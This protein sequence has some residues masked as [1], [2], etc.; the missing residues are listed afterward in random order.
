M[1][2]SFPACAAAPTTHAQ[3]TSTSRSVCLGFPLKNVEST[4]PGGVEQGLSFSETTPALQRSK[5]ANCGAS[6]PRSPTLINEL[7][8][9]VSSQ[10]VGLQTHARGVECQEFVQ[11]EVDSD[12]NQAWISEPVVDSL[13]VSVGAQPATVTSDEFLRGGHVVEHNESGTWVA[14]PL[15]N[16]PS[17]GVVDTR[18]PRTICNGRWSDWGTIDQDKPSVID[19]DGERNASI[20]AAG[21]DVEREVVEE[22]IGEDN[23]H[24]TLHLA[25]VGEGSE[26]STSRVSFALRS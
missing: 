2:D 5:V 24:E 7:V 21:D 26:K 23:V 17:S 9:P 15:C 22:L 10:K 6:V 13:V 18:Q 16:H 19:I 3:S 1:P 25:G 4:E 14:R 8:D 12:V 11:R 20:T